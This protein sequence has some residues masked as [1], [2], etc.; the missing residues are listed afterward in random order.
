MMKRI[1]KPFTLL[2]LLISL[3]ILSLVGSL[4]AV[5][6]KKLLDDYGFQQ[7]VTKMQDILRLAK[8][9]ACCHQTDVEVVF[10]KSQN[11]Y[12]IELKTDEPLFKQNP[13]FLK[14]YKFSKITSIDVEGSSIMFLGSG[15]VVPR[16]ELLICGYRKFVLQL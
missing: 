1:K 6:G 4:F 10:F 3:T 5:K 15:W 11:K 12:F 14:K 7:D 16:G 2:E 13:F 9:Y 8:E